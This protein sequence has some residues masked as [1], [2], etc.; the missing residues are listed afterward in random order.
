MRQRV[1]TDGPCAI[2][3]VETEPAMSMAV[4]T[5]RDT[6]VYIDFLP[7]PVSQGGAI[8]LTSPT[9]ALEFQHIRPETTSCHFVLGYKKS[10]CLRFFDRPFTTGS[11][12]LKC[13]GAKSMHTPWMETAVLTGLGGPCL[14]GSNGRSR[15][16]AG[17]PFGIRYRRS[18]RFR[19]DAGMRGNFRPGLPLW[20]TGSDPGQDYSFLS[21]WHQEGRQD[22]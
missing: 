17:R 5:A 7:C 14:A 6:S 9:R 10:G 18:K 15:G 12:C 21:S 20:D 11:N 22:G 2:A 3:P 19:G 1:C 4:A 13:A 8:L 16:A